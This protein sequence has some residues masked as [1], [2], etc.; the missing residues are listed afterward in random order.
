M[1]L[2]R[3]SW[4]PCLVA[5]AVVGSGAVARCQESRQ[6]RPEVEL[7]MHSVSEKVEAAADALKLTPEQRT[8]IKSVLESFASKRQALREQRRT[9]IESDLKAI[10]ELLTPEQRE[11][12]KD[13][14]EDRMQAQAKGEGAVVWLRDDLMRET[15]TQKLQS[16][17]DKLGLTP[18]QRTQIRERVAPSAEKYREQRRAR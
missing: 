1:R 12:V 13:F 7:L 2:P 3:Q 9:L 16:A 18:E 6:L 11:K 17:A 4:L 5:I 14:I 10:S 8:Q 15:L